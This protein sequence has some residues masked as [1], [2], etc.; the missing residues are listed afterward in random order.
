MNSLA[1]YP[2]AGG[3]SWYRLVFVAVLVSSVGVPSLHSEDAALLIVPRT[4]H[5]GGESS[6]TLS[7]LESESREALPRA[8][9]VLLVDG[10]GAPVATLFDGTTGADGHERVGFEVPPVGAGTYSIRAIVEGV[11]G[12]L[13]ATTVLRNT[14]GILIET[15]KPIYKP[16]QTIQGR[17]LLISNRLTPVEGVTE[18][19]FHDAKG[20]RLD[21]KQLTTDAFG[22]AAFE[23]DLAT[24]VN[25][26]TWKIKARSEG[27]ETSRDVRVEEYTLPRFD[28]GVSLARSW[29]LVDDAVQGSVEAR[30]FFGQDVEGTVTI[31]ARR[32]VGVWD[33]YAQLT[34]TLE[35]GS[36]SFELP[37]V[38]FVSG[39]PGDGGQGAVVLDIEAT[40]ATGETQTTSETLR[41][42]QAPVV[43]TLV[44]RSKTLKPGIAA[45]VVITSET[46]DGTPANASIDFT[47]V[48]FSTNGEQ[49]GRAEQ[50]VETVNGVAVVGLLPPAET[51]Y[52]EVFAATETEGHTAS[53]SAQIGS[54]YAPGGSFISLA[55][56][57]GTG[58]AAVGQVLE[59]S[60]IGTHPGTVYYEVFAGGRTVFS[61][62]TEA[63]SF[64]MT[65]TPDMV[66]AAK[67][68]AYKINPD[69]EVAADSLSLDVALSL[70]VSVAAG[71]D[72]STVK[73]GDPVDVTIDAGTGKRTML[74]VAIVDQSVLALGQSRLHLAEVFAELER[75][76]LEPQAEVH[77]GPGPVEED[78]FFGRGFPSTEGALDTLNDAG[79]EIVAS[80][81]LTVPAGSVPEHFFR[82]DDVLEAGPPAVPD[83]DDGGVA[84]SAAPEV[85]VRQFFPE[86]W[87]WQPTLMTDESGLATLSLTAPDSITSW[88]LSVVST[89]PTPAEGGS[90][91]GFGEDELTVFQDFFVEPSLPFSVTRGEEF[92]LKVDVFNY[93]D[94]P[95]QVVLDIAETPGFVMETEG[96]IIVPVEPNSATSISF[97]VQP[98]ELGR[99]PLSITATGATHADA[100]LREILVVP[101]GRPDEIVV[102]GVIEEGTSV[103]LDV[104]FPSDPE[105]G[106]E[107]V[108]GSARAFLNVTPSPVAQT[109]QGISDLLSMPYGCG[110]QNM[111]FLAPDIEIL[112]YLREIGELNPEIRATAEFYV[113]TGYQRQL[114]F[115]TTDGG[116]AAF[117]GADGALWLT[118]FVLSTFSGAREVRDID[119]T[120]LSRAAGMLVSRQQADGSFETDDFLIHEEMDGGLEN[121]YAMSAYVTNALAEYAGSEVAGALQNAANFLASSRTTLRGINDDAY[122]LSIAAVA[123]LKVPGFEAAAEATI[124]RLLALAKDD[125]VGLHWEPYPVESTG[126]AAVAL[127]EAAGG[128]GRPEAAGAIDW[129]TTQRNSLGGYGESTQDTVVAIRALFLAARKV[130]RDLD[131][132]LTVSSS[133][134]SLFEI[135][136]NESNFDL[137]HQH[138]L[139]ID[140]GEL[141]LASTGSGNVGFQLVKRFNVP[142]EF[143]PPPR[144]LVF[145]VRYDAEGIEVDDLVDVNVTIQYTGFKDRT[146]MVIADVGVPTG[147]GVVRSTVD[148]LVGE[149]VERVEIAGRKVIFYI[150]GLS[151]NEPLEFQFQVRSLYPVEAEGPISRAYEYYDAVVEAFHRQS[152]VFVL[153]PLP[154]SPFIRGDAN[155]DGLVELSDP[156]RTLGYLFLGEDD[157]ETFCADAADTDDDGILVLTDPILVLNHLFLGGPAPLPPFPEAGLDPTSDGLRRCTE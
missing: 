144:D 7:T 113:N 136:V 93:L 134:G 123:L 147:F 111:I 3:R 50:A 85:R 95:Q 104:T 116:F 44:P 94:T 84:N 92:P 69:N 38:G 33:Q 77:E 115:Q 80:R 131:V 82:F 155:R 100:V 57:D 34:G 42:A 126:Y 118:A 70:S 120:V 11:E 145:D 114:T 68:V 48:F 4:L 12:P 37:P 30:Y 137:L 14:P 151:Q 64:T 26:G 6:F 65:V 117:G 138:E 13:E 61:E 146:G 53:T 139:P 110:E 128:I 75:R 88:K 22:V 62:A 119:E 52:A 149:V 152:N 58:P 63:D 98:L 133:T 99:F 121:I 10:D 23:L 156:V 79:L 81:G 39:T 21:R 43:L 142:G 31:T 74:G 55:R 2:S 28:L 76:F 29:A 157:L 59:F 27:A 105:I 15:D 90:G 150:D 102:N 83:A 103:S 130:R 41:I 16:G 51:A 107:V 78:F 153:E 9:T 143:L 66:P 60:V 154:E 1:M 86:T 47:A 148:S 73:P 45:E 67:V 36:F 56:I 106:F 72:L 20:I 96:Q 129:L 140:Q 87:V 101:E 97:P 19:T 71:F 135:Q 141:T 125:G 132:Q 112:K 18:V 8:A 32:W 17:V 46:P 54:A 124:D 127:L 108:P 5:G 25:F 35:R 122:S 49:L 91:I 24:E 89:C 109:M 40:D